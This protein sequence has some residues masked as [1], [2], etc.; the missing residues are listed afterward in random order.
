MKAIVEYV[1][2]KAVDTATDTAVIAALKQTDVVL[3]EID[4]FIKRI[5][6]KRED[7]FVEVVYWENQASADAGL[8]S[9][10]QDERS[11]L[12]FS[13]IEKSSVKISYSEII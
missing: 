8:T 7:T 3:D 10:S 1:E 13:L 2:F 11:Q 9:F 4:G 6:A 12:L 5:L